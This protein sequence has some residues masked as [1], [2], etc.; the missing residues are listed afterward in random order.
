MNTVNTANIDSVRA[1]PLTRV[2]WYDALGSTRELIVWVLKNR[3]SDVDLHLHDPSILMSLVELII[4]ETHLPLIP[5]KLFKDME[6]M[7]LTVKPVVQ[8]LL[9]G[10]I[11]KIESVLDK[12]KSYGLQL[13]VNQLAANQITRE[14]TIPIVLSESRYC[15]C[16]TH[17][18]YHEANLMD[19]LQ[20][21]LLRMQSDTPSE[22]STGISSNTPVDERQWLLGG[23]TISQLRH[24][25]FSFTCELAL[26]SSTTSSTANTVSEVN[27]RSEV[28]DSVRVN[29]MNTT[30]NTTPAIVITPDIVSIVISLH[31]G[32]LGAV[33]QVTRNT[34]NHTNVMQRAAPQHVGTMMKTTTA[35]NTNGRLT[36]QWLCVIRDGYMRTK[37][38][39]SVF[40]VISRSHIEGVI[41][42]TNV[43]TSTSTT[44]SDDVESTVGMT[45]HK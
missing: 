11:A 20:T 17:K 19:Q 7:R 37:R 16:S 45:K 34:C 32:S 22:M 31:P 24:V 42:P 10:C 36:E 3:Y 5:E 26:P 2:S 28:N 29:T 18:P 13:V 35:T 15:C 33:L 38:D 14:H 8:N 6:I 4:E 44:H 1:I 39:D 43:S 9:M 23:Y 21:H 41:N 27:K 30:M 12:Y 25:E 40:T